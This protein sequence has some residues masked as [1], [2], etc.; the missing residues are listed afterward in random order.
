VS[1]EAVT[2]GYLHPDEASHSFMKSTWE[3]L[4]Y[5][6]SKHARLARGRSP[7]GMFCTSGGL[8]TGRNE[9]IKQ[10]LNDRDAPWFLWV[11]A[12]MGFAADSLERLMQ[13]AHSQLRPIVGALCFGNSPSGDD[14]LNGRHNTIFPTVMDWSETDEKFGLQPRYAY[15]V[16]S[17]VQCG[18]TGAAFVLIHRSVFKKIAEQYGETWYTRLPHP[19]SKGL[20]GEDVSFCLRAGSLGI[21]VHVHT[22]VQTN[23]WKPSYL[24]QSAYMSQLMAPP[25]T[26]EVDVLVPVM[27]RPQNAEP[28]MRSLLASTG[29]ARVTAIACQGDA[30]TAT[31]WRTAGAD[32]LW[33]DADPFGFKINEAYRST[34][35]PWLF[36]TG[37]DVR[38]RAGW[39]DHAQH[40]AKAHNADVIGTNDLG[41]ARVMNGEHA[42][43]MLIRRQYVDEVGASW[44]GP[45]VVCHEGYRHWYVDDE[46][47]TAAKQRGVWSAALASV[48]EHRHP[49]FGTAPDDEVYQ[50]GQSA[51]KNDKALFEKRLRQH[52]GKA[53]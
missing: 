21:P 47:V 14:G 11:D 26:D 10:F 36:I 25:A 20:L 31:A 18:S 35:T 30:E 46:I 4:M 7:L 28:F 50:L 3:M 5:D 23:H 51:A 8:E 52:R 32:V 2:M 42:T 6:T 45:G 29:L 27:R 48:V 49:I 44:D 9:T 38:F 17:V 15:E 37:D 22:G 40:I 34:S 12:D 16:N 24:S 19:K 43:H 41:S 53:A 39:L 13:V 33:V 1:A